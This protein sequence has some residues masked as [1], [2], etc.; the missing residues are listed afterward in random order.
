MIREVGVAAVPGS[1]FFREPVNHLI[2][3]HFARGTDVLDKPS[4]GW[5]S[6]PGFT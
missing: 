6:L 5:K 4:A 2:R 1:S 3:M